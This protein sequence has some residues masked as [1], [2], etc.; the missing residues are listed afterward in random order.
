MC[1]DPQ[2]ASGPFCVGNGTGDRVN[3]V[4]IR[5]V[6]AT[7]SNVYIVKGFNAKSRNYSF[8]IQE[9]LGEIFLQ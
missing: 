7:Q 6:H 4:S 8:N 9:L 5:K 2:E 1:L 3:R